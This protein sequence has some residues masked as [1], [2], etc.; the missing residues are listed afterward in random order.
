[1][2]SLLDMTPLRVFDINKRS[3][4]TPAINNFL[5]SSS[6]SPSSLGERT[7]I[8]KR[9]SASITLPRPPRRINSILSKDTP[10]SVPPPTENLSAAD[11]SQLTL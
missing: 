6:S 1:M 11:T 10:D 8:V 2:R 4:R 5:D 7:T 3:G 9:R